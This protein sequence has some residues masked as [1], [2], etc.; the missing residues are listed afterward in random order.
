MIERELTNG[1]AGERFGPRASTPHDPVRMAWST[2]AAGLG[3]FCM[4]A[5][6]SVLGGCQGTV[7]LFPNA[8]P[9]LR[10]TPAEF[11]ADAAKRQPFKADAPRG[12]EAAGRAE[13]NYAGDVLQVSNLL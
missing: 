1:F 11:A 7:S 5:L 13:V 9:A 2:A 6:I 4:A 12:G 3:L 8:D 10:K